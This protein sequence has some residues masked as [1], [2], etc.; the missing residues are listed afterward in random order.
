MSGYLENLSNDDENKTPLT[1]AIGYND[2]ANKGFWR[3]QPRQKIGKEKGRW[4]EMG[5]ELR[6]YFKDLFGKLGSVPGIALGSDGTPDGVRVLVRGQEAL[7]LPDGI[8]RFKTSDVRVAEAIIS[9]EYLK[10]KGI[11]TA[12]P[13]DL[14]TDALSNIADL[15]RA[16]ITPDDIRMANEGINSP[17]GVEL[18]AYK[19]SDEGK[20]IAQLEEQ[21]AVVDNAA[22][23]DMIDSAPMAGRPAAYRGLK[24]TSP[25]SGVWNYNDGST[26]YT[27]SQNSFGKWS[28]YYPGANS[29]NEN[30]D[31]YVSVD[32]AMERYFGAE[33]IS[34][35]A[36]KPSP[37]A[38]GF[39]VDLGELTKA[40]R[41]GIRSEYVS[42]NPETNAYMERYNDDLAKKLTVKVADKLGLD[43]AGSKNF[44]DYLAKNYNTKDYGSG[45]GVGRSS[46]SG[47]ERFDELVNNYAANNKPTPDAEADSDP[48]EA[49]ADEA[50]ATRAS[51]RQRFPAL[52]SGDVDALSSPEG[53]DAMKTIL[54]EAAIKNPDFYKSALDAINDPN[55]SGAEKL[56]NI[57]DALPLRTG[58]NPDGSPLSYS[59]GNSNRETLISARGVLEEALFKAGIKTSADDVYQRRADR[60]VRD[61]MAGKPTPDAEAVEKD[62]AEGDEEEEDLL[63]DVSPDEVDEL[64]GPDVDTSEDFNRPIVAKDRVDAIE[65]EPG[66][67]VTNPETDELMRVDDVEFNDKGVGRF[68]GQDAEGVDREFRAAPGQ[69]VSRVEFG[70]PGDTP[71]EEPTIGPAR[72]TPLPPTEVVP[73]TPTVPD[74]ATPVDIDELEEGDTVWD[75][76][77]VEI[78]TIRKVLEKSVDNR[79]RMYTKAQVVDSNGAVSTKSFME[80]REY[81]KVPKPEKPIAPEKPVAPTEPAAIPE[82]VVV[83]DVPQVPEV[84]E[85][86]ETPETPEDLTPPTKKAESLVPGDRIYNANGTSGTVDSVSNENGKV[87]VNYTDSNGESKKKRFIEDDDVAT[88]PIAP[89]PDQEASGTPATDIQK[90]TL[91][92]L[93]SLDSQNPIDDPI[94]RKQLVAALNA[95]DDGEP[96]DEGEVQDLIDEL[97]DYFMG[98]NVTPLN[99]FVTPSKPRPTDH[100]RDTIAPAAR[101]VDDM[102]AS[103]LKGI[104]VGNKRSDN[105]DAIEQ[106]L[107]QDYPDGFYVDAPGDDFQNGYMTHRRTI[108][109]GKTRHEVIVARTVGNKFV[110]VHRFTDLAT[111]ETSDFIS[112][113][114]RDTYS[115][116]HGLTNGIEIM[117][118]FFDG[119]ARPGGKGPVKPGEVLT[120]DGK[121]FTANGD[122]KRKMGYWRSKF[123]KRN[124]TLESIQKLADS[125]KTAKRLR[126]EQLLDELANKYDNDLD[127]MNRAHTIEDMRM[128]TLDEKY[129]LSTNGEAETLNLTTPSI[130]G[131]KERSKVESLEEA[132][133][134]NN[135]IDAKL[136]YQELINDTP[137][138]PAARLKMQKTVRD[139]IRA[140]IAKLPIT[141]AEKKALSQKLSA[142]ATNY[143]LNAKKQW[144]ID[145]D[146]KMPHVSGS[147]IV[148]VKK[149]TLAGW[150]N[151]VGDTAVGRV[152]R[153]LRKRG[154][155]GYSDYVRMEFIDKNGKI[156][157]V[158]SDLVTT[159]MKVVDPGTP[160][161][162][163]KPWLRGQELAERRLGA[164]LVQKLRS[165]GAAA[166]EDDDGGED[167]ISVNK[168]ASELS[169]G[170]IYYDDD[171]DAVGTILSVDTVVKKGK[172]YIKVTFEDADGNIDT[173]AL[174]PDDEVGPG[175]KA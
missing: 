19:E 138:N 11:A 157:T 71:I 173:D 172:T 129:K 25:G 52:A 50:A 115:A 174:F 93:D 151:N 67:F 160:L 35:K 45:I 164:T 1:A 68:T 162:E 112:H 149:G 29:D 163:Y 42:G 97:N 113:D 8:Y 55:S 88:Q 130:I 175:P 38:E 132:I 22:V 91:E 117:S 109:G 159:N 41:K 167:D 150:T 131:N 10:S 82:P 61:A 139:L 141:A 165:D 145:N 143:M 30:L 118:K 44:L 54:N 46:T 94:L 133:F 36:G 168:P 158:D 3:V 17:E 15:E 89:S 60:L 32:D 27:I 84:P 123:S 51:W 80:D 146:L 95:I 170:D 21:D 119:T 39:G 76:D 111:G 14:D 120:G 37:D 2:G 103:K 31:D 74:N 47:L 144:S 23:G 152:V 107:E 13:T 124:R 108:D 78:G 104:K 122:W 6:A 100:G 85:V 18:A 142:I 140:K 169:A 77:G 57:A 28:I 64:L 5:A 79:F 105:P 48:L 69:I 81:S 66:D 153:V 154:P 20:A 86:P 125:P 90:E 96:L 102:R 53:L 161:T 134:T 75:A 40:I 24:E 62:I 126:G 155:R 65:I 72:T 59:D 98:R 166:R 116:I 137:D 12:V 16:D 136:R 127:A 34:K 147:G 83:P 114:Y 58:T 110:T 128:L 171:G 99:Q 7:G 9:D 135:A 101:S 106:Q 63:D 92:E 73:K 56:Q 87:T 148:V 156:K 70:E 121:Y 4:I 49:M 43:A 26:N 33:P